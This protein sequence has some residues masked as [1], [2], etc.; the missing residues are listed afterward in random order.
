MFSL[1][2]SL[3]SISITICG[4]TAASVSHKIYSTLDLIATAS[5][6]ANSRILSSASW[7]VSHFALNFIQILFIDCRFAWWLRVTMWIIGRSHLSRN[8]ILF[9]NIFLCSSQHSFTTSV[10]RKETSLSLSLVA[11]GGKLFLDTKFLLMTR[12]VGNCRL[13]FPLVVA[14]ALYVF[15]FASKQFAKR[16]FVI[17][18]LY[19]MRI[20][21]CR[22]RDAT[23][24]NF[25]AAGK[26]DEYFSLSNMLVNRSRQL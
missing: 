6:R 11:C 2:E 26:V 5:Y 17:H 7:C 16:Y 8:L 22:A 14:L 19:H 1:R 15:L 4:Q 25:R 21:F 3:V 12:S 10:C 23:W 20:I 24:I 18:M 9:H 13:I